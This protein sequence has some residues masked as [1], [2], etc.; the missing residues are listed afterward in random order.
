MIAIEYEH[1]KGSGLA[2]CTRVFADDY[3]VKSNRG[4]LRADEVVAGDCLE[5]APRCKCLVISAAPVV[6]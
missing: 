1:P 2:G 5:T 4:N 6:E 3:I